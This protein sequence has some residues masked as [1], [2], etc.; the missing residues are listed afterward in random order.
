ME[1]T[2]H[3]GNKIDKD[4]ADNLKG[5]ITEIFESGY[6]NHMDQKTIRKALATVAQSVEV[7]HVIITD[8][9]FTGDKVVNMNED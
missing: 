1:N 8:N 3:V 2:I 6:K 5:V 9:N 4:S 7:K